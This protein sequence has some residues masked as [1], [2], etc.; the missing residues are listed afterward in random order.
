M[1]RTLLALLAVLVPGLAFMFERPWLNVAAG[2][3]VVGGIGLLGWWLWTT[4]KDEAP[5]PPP[6]PT[7]DSEDPE[8]DLEE[9]GIVDIKPEDAA[10]DAET[11]SQ[12]DAPE[13]DASDPKPGTT[14]SPPADTTP[15]ATEPP[16]PSRTDAR[17]T[18]DAPTPAS[19]ATTAEGPPVL[20]PLLE[21]LRAAIDAQTVC[22][23]VQEEIALTYRIEAIASTHS[24]VQS[25]GT[26]DTQTPLLTATMSRESVTLRPL[27]E[28]EIAIE[29]L[30]YYDDPPTVDHLAAAPVSRPDTSSTT[31]LLA[32]APADTDLGTS[33][34]RSLLK[35]FA[36]TVA[37]LLS[38][39]QA[40][41]PPPAPGSSDEQVNGQPSEPEAAPESPASAAP[42]DSS[43]RPRREIVAEEMEAAQA[44]DDDL[45]L[46]LVHLNR[47]ESIARRGDEAVASA[48]RRFHA[49]LEQ[50]A[51]SQR[52]EQ[53]GE[54]TYG[55]FFRKHPDAV[56]PQVADLETTMAREDGE[57]E[58]GV[59]VGVAVWGTRIDTPKA[60]RAEAT[61]ALR[62][63]YET[64][65]PTIIT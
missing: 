49:R 65:A 45:A 58:G 36:E 34:A 52:I 56:E 6:R 48:E 20:G 21:S 38:T 14:T 41:S 26:F 53:F 27:A 46:A 57:L 23:L 62:E 16:P 18:D 3:I 59:S 10:D 44:A 8:P 50:L 25:S 31:F 1:L 9:M 43:P 4:V 33:E 51:P 24:S 11:E 19:S 2:L 40:P 29:D 12:P 60:L 61:K 63:A 7:P 42:D 30:R 37:L 5:D 22:L 17:Q 47:A 15:S 35:H 28:E 32:D 39:R 54:L 55:I 64:G 13:D